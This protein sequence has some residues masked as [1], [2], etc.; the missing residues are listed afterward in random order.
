MIETW[1]IPRAAQTFRLKAEVGRTAPSRGPKREAKREPKREAKHTTPHTP[2]AVAEFHGI[3]WP[4]G[5][6]EMGLQGYQ[7]PPGP[8]QL[9]AD[10]G[11]S[12][13]Y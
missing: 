6:V 12:I 5:L 10:W 1:T 9:K 3:R 13:H 7:T 4:P 11:K 8:I 2:L